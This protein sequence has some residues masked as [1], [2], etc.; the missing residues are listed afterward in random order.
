L[1]HPSALLLFNAT[2]TSIWPK[3]VP[4]MDR[5]FFLLLLMSTLSA[6][7]A[8]AKDGGGDDDGGDDDNGGDGGGSGGGS[9]DDDDNDG[10]DDKDRD[11]KR[12][13]DA[14]K[15][16]RAGKAMPLK[17]ALARLR[18]R[19]AGRVIDAKLTRQGQRLV[20]VFKVVSA[21][22]AVSTLRMD[23]ESGRIAGIFGF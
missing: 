2:S 12:E 18:K 13:E 21:T 7:P 19:D 3:K 16:V 1:R 23:A 4:T 11:D 17:D 22:G 5:R 6:V 8:A 10:D 20:Y 15:A 9:D 14:R